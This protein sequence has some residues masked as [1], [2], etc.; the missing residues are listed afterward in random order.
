MAEAPPPHDDD[1]YGLLMFEHKGQLWASNRFWLVRAGR[2]VDGSRP[3]EQVAPILNPSG[4]M[5]PLALRRVL[6]RPVTI[7][8]DFVWAAV[9]ERPDESLTVLST[10][11]LNAAAPAWDR[12]GY[13]VEQA[14]D[15]PNGPV[16]FRS[17]GTLVAV[18]MSIRT[19]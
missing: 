18:L 7:K 14:E 13:V 3:T 17:D 1:T 9:Y 4:P 19:A 8:A 12:D 11:Y 10:S 15:N 5:V 6:G 16:Y 2:E